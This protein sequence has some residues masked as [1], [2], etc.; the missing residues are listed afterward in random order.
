MTKRKRPREL[1]V[2]PD[3][4]HRPDAMGFDL[5]GT[6][7]PMTSEAV[8]HKVDAAFDHPDSKLRIVVFTLHDELLVKV[9]G[10]P[11]R[12][13]LELLEQLVESYTKIL[14]GH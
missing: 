2:D 1:E 13:D 5:D 14:K 6:P 12:A 11:S 9:M 4:V 10:G 3:R 7:L 8:N